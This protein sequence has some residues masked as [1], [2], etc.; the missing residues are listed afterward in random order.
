MH[1]IDLQSSD[2]DKLLE[3]NGDFGRALYWDDIKR[4]P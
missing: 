2:V 1:L 3:Q 4:H